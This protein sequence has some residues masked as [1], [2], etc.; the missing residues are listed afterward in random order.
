MATA[1]IYA[2]FV[3]RGSFDQGRNYSPADPAM[4]GKGQGGPLPLGK[5]KKF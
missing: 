2:T 4:R 5:K 3:R 1:T